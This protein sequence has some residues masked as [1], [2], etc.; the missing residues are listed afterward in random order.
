[1]R[2]RKNSLTD[3]KD[4]ETTQ[5]LSACVRERYVVNTTV[6]TGARGLR[7]SFKYFTKKQ[8]KTFFEYTSTGIL[9][10]LLAVAGYELSS[11]TCLG[12]LQNAIC[13]IASA[14]GGLEEA[15]GHTEHEHWQF[16]MLRQNFCDTPTASEAK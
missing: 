16:C 14:I 12:V 6:M 10:S 11:A 2:K 4:M 7:G 5:R 13:C 9:A 8:M 1:M 3:L 15:F